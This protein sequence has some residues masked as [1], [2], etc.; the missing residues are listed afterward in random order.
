MARE[1]SRLET[2]RRAATAWHTQDFPSCCQILDNLNK[3][4]AASVTVSLKREGGTAY[5]SRP[6]GL[7]LANLWTVGRSEYSSGPVPG[8]SEHTP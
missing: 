1:E 6:T 3:S 7:T 5:K 4:S 8:K 2:G